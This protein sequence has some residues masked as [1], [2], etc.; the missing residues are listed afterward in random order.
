MQYQVRNSKETNA[1][2]LKYNE[3]LD[4][5]KISSVAKAWNTK[6]P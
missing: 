4:Q 2:E 6:K 5:G 1:V 3:T